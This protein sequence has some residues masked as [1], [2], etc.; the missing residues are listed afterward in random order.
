MDWEELTDE[1]EKKIRQDFGECEENFDGC[2]CCEM[3]KALAIIRKYTQDL[4]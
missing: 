1:L 4:D 3:R 2:V